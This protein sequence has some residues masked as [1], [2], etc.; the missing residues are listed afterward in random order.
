MS[1]KERRCMGIKK[2][3][4]FVSIVHSMNETKIEV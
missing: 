2:A 1:Q 3:S 4:K